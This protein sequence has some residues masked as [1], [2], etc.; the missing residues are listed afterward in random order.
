MMTARHHRTE[1]RVGGPWIL[2]Q[3]HARMLELLQNGQRCTGA[4]LT[5]CMLLLLL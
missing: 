3:N 4:L 5:S 2:G 1:V